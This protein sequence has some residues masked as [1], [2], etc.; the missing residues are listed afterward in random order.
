MGIDTEDIDLLPAFQCKFD[1]W[2]D[3]AKSQLIESILLNFA[4]PPLYFD[5]SS[6]KKGVVIELK[7]TVYHR[8]DGT[9][10]FIL[11]NQPK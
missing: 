4:I 8:Q 2:T 9:P 7:T 11:N 3:E 5:A 10:I 6:F 1:L